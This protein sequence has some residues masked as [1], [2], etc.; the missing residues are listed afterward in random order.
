MRGPYIV[1][2]ILVLATFGRQVS[3]YENRWGGFH[4][5]VGAAQIERPLPIGLSANG[6]NLKEPAT[7]I[8]PNFTI[9]TFAG[10]NQIRPSAAYDST[11]N[12][13]LVVWSDDRNAIARNGFDIYGQLLGADGNLIGRDFP[14]STAPRDQR[15]PMVIYDQG[16]RQY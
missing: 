14:I 9:S 10:S 8:G 5:E 12:Q 7:P 13:H 3:A 2:L 1:P 4:L 11:K 6:E 16:E 15:N